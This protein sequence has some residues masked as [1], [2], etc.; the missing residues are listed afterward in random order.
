MVQ[1]CHFWGL[2]VHT[3]LTQVEQSKLQ[4]L[5]QP[6]T[7]P[8][9]HGL[10]MEAPADRPAAGGLRRSLHTQAATRLQGRWAPDP[11]R[12]FVE[13]KPSAGVIQSPM[14]AT[15]PDNT[16]PACLA[17]L[18]WARLACWCR[19]GCC[20]SCHCRNSSD[21]AARQANGC[22]S[23]LVLSFSCNQPLPEFTHGHDQHTD[24]PD[25]ALVHATRV[26]TP[27]LSH[28]GPTQHMLTLASP[29]SGLCR[30]LRSH[31]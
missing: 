12:C 16:G 6:A 31:P 29:D 30:C 26:A 11:C 10:E 18:I 1:L 5:A 21:T 2:T 27:R 15:S 4:S 24:M 3:Q 8:A 25:S 28:V 7:I 23:V 14:P 19:D 9:H 17:Q 13:S 22:V 20:G